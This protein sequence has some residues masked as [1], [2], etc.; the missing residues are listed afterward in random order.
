MT[1]PLK[2]SSWNVTK[3]EPLAIL[4]L[5]LLTK[6]PDS[7]ENNEQ[8]LKS[9]FIYFSDN[10]KYWDKNF[11]DTISK[12]EQYILNVSSTEYWTCLKNKNPIQRT[13]T[14]V[15]PVAENGC[16]L[17]NLV[18]DKQKRLRNLKKTKGELIGIYINY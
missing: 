12:D 6:K 5:I 15:R 3:L 2:R 13:I 14:N 8:F 4:I 16:H 10:T 7:I 9:A 18:Q 17:E 11:W 1:N